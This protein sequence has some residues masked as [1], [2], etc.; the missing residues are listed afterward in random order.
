MD[1]KVFNIGKLK[2]FW[3]SKRSILCARWRIKFVLIKEARHTKL[4]S[5]KFTI[6]LYN[7][8][9]NNNGSRFSE[10]TASTRQRRIVWASCWIKRDSPQYTERRSC[11]SSRSITSISLFIHE[12][13]GIFVKMRETANI[14]VRCYFDFRAAK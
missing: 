7:R 13:R 8:A 14:D 4:Q 2:N 5:P 12:R 6:T 10:R 1:N 11:L 9:R 3:W